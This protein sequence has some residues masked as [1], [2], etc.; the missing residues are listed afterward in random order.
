ME[1]TYNNTSEKDDIHL[2]LSLERLYRYK[3]RISDAHRLY[4]NAFKLFPDDQQILAGLIL[5]S[6]TVKDTEALLLALEEFMRSFGMDTDKEINGIAG[7]ASLCEGLG[8]RML[9]QDTATIDAYT[10]AEAAIMINPS[11][12]NA[13][14]P[15]IR[16]Y[17]I[18]SNK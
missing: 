9:E 3:N 18:N 10:M 12:W 1:H 16:L 2:I 8:R 11:C 13:H 5:T 15:D 4:L 6:A 14:L 17:R 7:I